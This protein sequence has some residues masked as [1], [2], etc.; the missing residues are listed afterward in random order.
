MEGATVSSSQTSWSSHGL[1]YQTKNTHGVTHG[2]GHICGRG[3][4]C[5]TS[6]GREAL[7]PEGVQCP[8][9][10]ECQCGRMGVGRGWEHL[11]RIRG[12]DD[13]IGGFQRGDLERGKYLKCK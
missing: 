8:S 11:Q 1:D 9:I 6:V 7:G 10:G 2:T 13:E 3:W 12:R 4:L 5:W